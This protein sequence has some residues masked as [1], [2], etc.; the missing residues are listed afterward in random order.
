MKILVVGGGGREH[1]LGWALARHGHSL[2][3]S[4][5]N[6]AFSALGAV[7]VGDP[8]ERAQA[9]Q[10]D[11]VVIGPEAPLAAGL[12]DKLDALSIP[13]FGPTQA[14][15]RLE[16]SKVW[17]KEFMLRHGLPTARAQVIAA[18]QPIPVMVNGVVK[19]DG[20]AAGKGVWVCSDAAELRRGVA[21][22]TRMHPEGRVLLE[23]R[24]EGPEVSVLAISDGTRIVPLPCAR[25]HK[26][27]FDG[28][29]GPNTGGM[30]AVAPVAIAEREEC[31]EI[32]QRAVT[33]MALEGTPFRGVLFGGFMLTQK[34]PKLLEFNARF[35]DPECQVLMALLDEDPAPWLLGAARGRLPGASMRSCV[36]HACCVVVTSEGYPERSADAVITGLPSDA[37]DLI[38]FHSGTRR[39]GDTLRAVGGRVVGVT[40]LGPS[41]E[42]A[43]ARAYAGVRKVAFAGAAWRGDIGASGWGS[44]E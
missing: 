13:A 10:P 28:D 25:D 42:A 43:R 3:F 38:V 22:A 11:L 35:G 34:G 37:D 31:V 14:A 29:R 30:G 33:A 32:L 8:L 17:S 39:D 6:P 44:R 2:Y 16:T 7:D 15:A 9:I 19:V 36:A 24:L 26:R 20:L 5:E 40:G 41:A 4:S 1:A 18:G 27:R 23:E 12:V 21:E